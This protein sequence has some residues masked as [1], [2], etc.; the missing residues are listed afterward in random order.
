ML[1]FTAL[2][3]VVFVILRG[4]NVYNDARHVLFAYPPLVV[5]CAV[6]ID[7]AAR[8]LRWPPPQ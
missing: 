1:A 5:I 8:A 4:S 2:F 6:A 3:P 7:C